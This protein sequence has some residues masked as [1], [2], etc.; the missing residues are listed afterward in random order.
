MTVG[1]MQPYFFPYLG[2]WQLINAVDKFVLLDDVNFIMKGYINRNNI[3]IN[4][5]PHLFTI[6]LENP[7]R[8]KL[9]SETRLNF[10]DSARGS[11]LRMVTFAYKKAPHFSD[12]YPVL[13]AVVNNREQSLTAFLKH[14]IKCAMDYLGV[15]TEILVS[16]E[17]EKDGSQR[18]QDRIIAINR[19]LGASR[20]INA[21]GGQKLYDGAAFASVG[22]DLR[23][24]KMG[25]VSYRQFKNDFVPNLSLIDV[26]MFNSSCE[27][28]QLLTQY[29]L[30]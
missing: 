19:A 9:I 11:F 21:I 20:Y 5:A 24:L 30:I 2:Y 13:E 3:L 27:V 16:S 17:I 7:S 22:I 23:F 15:A 18:A 6:P 12:F 8:N 1:V 10:D 29:V 28:R 26:L 14:S 25:E 4:G